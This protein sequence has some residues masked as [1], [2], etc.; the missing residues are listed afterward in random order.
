MNYSNMINGTNVEQD[1]DVV[2]LAFHEASQK[3]ATPK[4]VTSRMFNWMV[5]A[6]QPTLPCG[7]IWHTEL[8][9]P[10]ES[11]AIVPFATYWGERSG[12]QSL[13][14]SKGLLSR[15]A[16]ESNRKYYLNHVGNH[17]LVIPIRRPMLARR[18]A[19]L[20]NQACGVPYSY[21]RYL[22]ASAWG[23]WAVCCVSAT[24]RAPA[25]CATLAARVLQRATAW[26]FLSSSTESYSPVQLYLASKQNILEHPLLWTSA[27]L[28]SHTDPGGEDAKHTLQHGDITALMESSRSELRKGIRLLERECVLAILESH[29]AP[30]Q[31]DSARQLGLA[32]VKYMLFC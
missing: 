28:D 14:A 30:A 9:I 12:W 27:T 1:C 6:F 19:E 4:A 25:H 5:S 16:V 13:S 2:Y 22:T 11:G 29:D 21:K 15:E 26:E 24:L 10:S 8:W 3:D 18:A 7:T 20:A 17:W 31:R 32:L 23:K